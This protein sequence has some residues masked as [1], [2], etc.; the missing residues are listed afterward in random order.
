MKTKPW[1][2]RM[3]KTSTPLGVRSIDRKAVERATSIATMMFGG[4]RADRAA[5]LERMWGI[6]TLMSL[7]TKPTVARLVERWI[8]LERE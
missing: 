6:A 4:Q 5:L 2:K 7:R 8:E 3:V 1:N